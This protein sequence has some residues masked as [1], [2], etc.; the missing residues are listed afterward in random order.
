MPKI[1]NIIYSK[2]SI[3][4]IIYSKNSIQFRNDNIVHLI[5]LNGKSLDKNMEILIK[6]KNIKRNLSF[7][8]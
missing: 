1:N 8:I 4:N 7:T 2:N 3:N 5:N 6:N